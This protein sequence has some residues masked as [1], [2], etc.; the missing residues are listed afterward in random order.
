MRIAQA[1]LLCIA[2]VSNAHAAQSWQMHTQESS[3]AF[4]ASYDETPFNG[5]FERFTVELS[6]DADDLAN[7]KLSTKIDVTS[8][9]TNSHDRDQA[10]AESD[11]FYFSKFPQATFVSTEFSKRDDSMYKVAGILT[12]RDIQHEISFPFTWQ[13]VS[14]HQAR[15]TAQFKLDRRDFDIG[16]GDWKQD[17]TI[18]FS[19]LV[20]LSL[21][22]QKSL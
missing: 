9:N 3:L 2:V 15:V 12:I 16:T 20:K 4:I 7:N 1:L 14:D 10:L 11:W 18:G 13:Q 8:V 6:F 5:E 19:V 17:E 22:L 21:L